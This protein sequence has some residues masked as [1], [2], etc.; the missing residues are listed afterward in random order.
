MTVCSANTASARKVICY[1]DICGRVV[2]AVRTVLLLE[3][4]SCP[5]ALVRAESEFLGTPKP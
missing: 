3:D 4:W 5:S 1:R 2:A